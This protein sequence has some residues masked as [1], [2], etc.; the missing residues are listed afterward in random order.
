MIVQSIS[1]KY[2]SW[3]LRRSLERLGLLGVAGLGILA[4]SA[5]FYFSGLRSEQDELSAL[6]SELV[7]I[8]TSVASRKLP[9][10]EDQL[11]TFYEFFP[12]VSTV[13]DTL[14]A[15][16]HEAAFANGV[17]LDQGEYRVER[18]EREKL[19]R[20]GVLLPIK[21]DYV[22]IRKFLSQALVEM[23]YASLDSIEFQRQQVSDATLE[24]QVKMTFFLANQ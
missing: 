10:A 2:L 9:Q 19:V 1:L 12:A 11:N 3:H 8:Q 24:A 16:L 4:F 18:K 15:K 22:H 23:P 7:A 14:L 17:M 21:G 6:R 20:Y 13:P 5:M